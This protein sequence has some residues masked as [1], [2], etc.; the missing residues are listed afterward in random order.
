MI[1][2]MSDSYSFI[3][4]PVGNV[5]QICGHNIIKKQKIIQSIVKYFSSSKYVENE[6]VYNVFHLNGEEV[7]RNYYQSNIIKSITDVIEQLSINKKSLMYLTIKEELNKYDFK[8]EL[9][10]LYEA[11]DLLFN[12][13]NR[14]LPIAEHNLFV[15]Y[16]SE[17]VMGLINKSSVYSKEVE[18]ISRLS[19]YELLNNYIELFKMKSDKQIIIFQNIDHYL[20]IEEYKDFCNRCIN[21]NELTGHTIIFSTSLDGYCM[22]DKKMANNIAVI[23]DYDYVFPDYNKLVD[24]IRNR[25]PLN[26]QAMSVNSVLENIIHNIGKKNYIREM[27]EQVILKILNSALQYPDKM[28]NKFNALE[29]NYLAD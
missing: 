13:I 6:E 24:Y 2:E 3:E 7:G 27:E 14:K 8:N 12:Q 4:L 28:K 16:E 29:W 9:E 17:D 19:N 26:K 1:L 5:T 25:Y 21:I 11:L 10:Q 18:D 23:N 22:F 20:T 15:D